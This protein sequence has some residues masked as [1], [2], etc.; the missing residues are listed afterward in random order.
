MNEKPTYTVTKIGNANDAKPFP[1]CWKCASK[2]IQPDLLDDRCVE[3][4]GCKELT[5]K[6]WEDGNKPDDSGLTYQHNCPLF[7]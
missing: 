4:V 7:K 5:K 2:M 3:I 6:Q 1:M